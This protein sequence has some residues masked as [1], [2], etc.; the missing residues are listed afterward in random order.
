MDSNSPFNKH[1]DITVGSI[2]LGC[3]WNGED[4]VSYALAVEDLDPVALD[5]NDIACLK[6]ALAAMDLING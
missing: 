3:C 6:K 5:A 4:L 2:N 1:F